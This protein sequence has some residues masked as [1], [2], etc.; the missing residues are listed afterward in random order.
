MSVF[1]ICVK[2]ISRGN[3]IE[4]GAPAPSQEKSEKVEDTPRLH[5]AKT[6]IIFPKS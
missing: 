3:T 6:V 1:V 5:W 4:N 2:T